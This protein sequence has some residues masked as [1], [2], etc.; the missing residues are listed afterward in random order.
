MESVVKYTRFP[1]E[2]ITSLISNQDKV[3]ASALMGKGFVLGC[4]SGKV[5]VVSFAGKVLKRSH[6]HSR[7]VNAIS[8]DYE[9]LFFVSCS[10]DCTVVMS[11]VHQTSAEDQTYNLGEPVKCVIM[12]N[13][14]GSSSVSSAADASKDAR[15]RFQGGVGM[16]KSSDRDST[17]SKK[18]CFVAGCASGMLSRYKASW[19]N[20]VH[21]VLFAG[22][23]TAVSAIAW[24]GGNLIAWTDATQMRVLDVGTMSAVC[25][26][27]APDGVGVGSLFPSSLVWPSETD[28]YVCWADS[29]RHLEMK[30]VSTS[31][32]NSV[33]STISSDAGEEGRGN[34]NG[35]NGADGSPSKVHSDVIARTVTEWQA[36]FIIC[37]I[38]NFDC[39]HLA[40][41]G[42][43][44]PEGQMLP[45]SPSSSS[46]PSEFNQPEIQI[47]NRKTGMPLYVD[48]LPLLGSAKEGPW[49]YTLLSSYH[50]HLQEMALSA[51]VNLSHAGQGNN[52]S[53]SSRKPSF[54]GQG[55][56]RQHGGDTSQQWSLSN[57]LGSRGGSRGLDPILYIIAPEDVVVARAKAVDDRIKKAL[58]NKELRVAAELAVGDRAGLRAFKFVDV[59]TLYISDLLA[60]QQ[61]RR[62]AQ[63]CL[64]LFK[65]DPI[66]WERWVYAFAK[67]NKLHAVFVV[68]PTVAPRL[69]LMG[70]ELVADELLRSATYHPR[71]F[72]TMVE[73]WAP[74][75]PA[76]LDVSAMIARLEGLR[77]AHPYVFC[78]MFFLLF[79][80]MMVSMSLSYP[81]IAAF[82][83]SMTRHDV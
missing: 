46:S 40:L 14:M 1:S 63:E 22:T 74:V 54:S 57:L 65:D 61:D 82:L 73:R 67:A 37:G 24:N 13:Q 20:Q 52:G 60:Q 83:R 55:T 81:S 30:N 76:I 33:G 72:L 26:L 71:H 70:Y 48:A 68:M 53:S 31:R 69:P 32:Q 10:D 77:N 8:V 28:L 11:F 39:G 34:G 29:F 27:E 36:D 17:R 9:G 4:G 56:H 51:D 25:Y 64:R 47:V 49:S 7:A 50:A 16:K 59:L 79:L 58:A 38:S 78:S 2:S 15:G 75:K 43:A 35:G 80:F 41:L 45:S 44:P 19:F 12:Q 6:P 5:Y 18:I 66:L 23:G 3:T 42:Y 62:A 21:D